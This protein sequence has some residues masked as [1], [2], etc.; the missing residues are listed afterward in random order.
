MKNREERPTNLDRGASQREFGFSDEAE[1]TLLANLLRPEFTDP[2][3]AD[4]PSLSV[5]SD[6]DLMELVV[7]PRNLE[8]AWR[9]LLLQSV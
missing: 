9:N 8:R 3:S 6:A 2:A 1:D 7:H 5:A 4:T